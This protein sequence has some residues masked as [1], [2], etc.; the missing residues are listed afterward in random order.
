MTRKSKREIE[1]ALEDLGGG[2]QLARD[3]DP[4]QNQY[5][6]DVEA[7]INSLA[8]DNLAHKI[9]PNADNPER[10]RRMLEHIR[11]EYGIDEDRDDAVHAE[12][13]GRAAEVDSQYWTADDALLPAIICGPA[14][15]D[16]NDSAHFEEL[17]DADDE[18]EAAE[19]I[20]DAVYHWLADRGDGGTVPAES[21]A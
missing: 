14:L 6:D 8:L 19:M 10:T 20:V 18:D 1:R 7:F 17:L 5:S 2:E 15:L 3:S 13:R 9:A 4:I 12:L 16:P 11:E 21:A